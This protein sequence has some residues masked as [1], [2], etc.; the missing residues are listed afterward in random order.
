MSIRFKDIISGTIIWVY[1]MGLFYRNVSL[2]LFLR[3]FSWSNSVT[4]F[5]DFLM[6][7][8]TASISRDLFLRPFSGSNAGTIFWDFFLGPFYGSVSWDI[9]KDYLLGVMLGPFSGTKEESE[10]T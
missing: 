10:G 2:D 9:F 7:L 5:W 6:G 8:F 3:P 1:F 4:I